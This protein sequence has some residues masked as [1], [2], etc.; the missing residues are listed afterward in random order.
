MRR[1]K[2]ER[3]DLKCEK[4]GMTEQLTFDHIV[5]KMFLHS[6]GLTKEQMFEDWL[7]KILCRPCNVAKKSALD[8]TDP[9]T[10]QIFLRLL[11]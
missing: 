9:R 7:L 2:K 6:F 3:T 11:N 10:K 5:P 4:C 1:W 8:F